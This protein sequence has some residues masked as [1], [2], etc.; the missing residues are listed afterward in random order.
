ME[1]MG[2]L[3]RPYVDRVGTLDEIS[4]AAPC[5]KGHNEGDTE[6]IV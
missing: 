5:R 6:V 1:E 3:R 4:E 2:L